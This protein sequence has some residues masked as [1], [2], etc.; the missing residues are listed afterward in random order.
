MSKK[1]VKEN[2]NK[3]NYIEKYEEPVIEV[4]E[5]PVEITDVINISAN[6]P[7]LLTTEEGYFRTSNKNINIQ[8]R[9]ATMVSFSIPFGISEVIIEN[10]ENG[11]IVQKTYRVV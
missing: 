3:E 7:I 6:M 5:T 8:K 10:K 9:T 11:D 4:I 2:I 1:I